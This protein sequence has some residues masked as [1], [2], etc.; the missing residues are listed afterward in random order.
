MLLLLER[1]AGGRVPINR[2]IYCYH[3]QADDLRE[4]NRTHK[5]IGHH[6]MRVL[7]QCKKV[8]RNISK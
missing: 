3:Y 2:Y 6:F 4:S 5:D 7:G 8:M 1:L